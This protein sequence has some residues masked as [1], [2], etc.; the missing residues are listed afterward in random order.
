M[1]DIHPKWAFLAYGCF[2]LVVAFSCIFLSREAEIEFLEGEEEYV[3][4][5]SSEYLDG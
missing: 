4:H 2:G 1:E 3:S 5:Y